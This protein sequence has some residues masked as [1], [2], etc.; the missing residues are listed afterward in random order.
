MATCKLTDLSLTFEVSD[1][2]EEISHQVVLFKV[3]ASDTQ[4][5][6]VWRQVGEVEIDISFFVNALK[7]QL[8]KVNRVCEWGPSL[9][10]VEAPHDIDELDTWQGE[11]L[12]L[13]FFDEGLTH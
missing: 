3:Q 10:A 9:R 2:L 11:F 13:H 12:L 1:F 6:Q 8:M 7:P 5:V 4:Y